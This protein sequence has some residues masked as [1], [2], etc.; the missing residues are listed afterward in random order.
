MNKGEIIQ[1]VLDN[2]FLIALILI[3][4]YG[5]I[6]GMYIRNTIQ[7]IEVCKEQ[8]ITNLTGTGINLTMVTP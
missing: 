3:V 8:I 4:L 7:V 2:I 6:D 1:K 5:I